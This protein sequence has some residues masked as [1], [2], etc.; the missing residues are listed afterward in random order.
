MRNLKALFM[1]SAAFAAMSVAS[2]SAQ[3]QS[4]AFGA[5]STSV[6][7]VYRQLMDCLYDQAQG[8]AGKPGPMAKA[9]MCTGFNTS[10]FHGM[11]LYA[12]TGS[13]NGKLVLRT[14]DKSQIGIVSH[15]VPYTN[16]SKYPGS[17][18]VLDTTGYDGVQ[19]IGSD[20]VVN[21]TDII[22][23][24]AGGTT[25]PQSKFGNLIQLP[26]VIETIGLGLSE[27][28]GNNVWLNVLTAGL[29]LSRNA[30]CGIVSGHITQ[31]NNPILTALNGGVLGTGNIIFVHR[32]DES[33]ATF[34]LSNA[35]VAQCRYEFGPNNET[36]ATIVSY[37]F[38]W[39]DRSQSCS[40]PLVA[41]GSNQVNWPDQFPTDQCG[42]A[43]SNPGGGH[44]ASARVINQN[45]PPHHTTG[46]GALVDF[47][48]STNGAIGYASGNFSI[49]Q[50]RVSL[51]PFISWR[52]ANLQSQWD[53]ANNTGK[54]QAP[55]WQ[56]AQKA[57]ATLIPQFDAT[58][59]ANPLTWSL[60]G[61]APNPVVAGAYPISG[62]S[63]IEMY[64]C[65]RNH[66]TYDGPRANGIPVDNNA[67]LWLKIWLDF[68]YGT[69]S[70]GILNDTGFAQIP[71]VWQ[72]EIYSLLND[73]V[74]GP[75]GSGCSGKVG[76]Y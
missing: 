54:F 22:N 15:S 5:G 63:W 6:Q 56:G 71:G 17:I 4:Y 67:F 55:T 14:N 25:S 75:Q 31:W 61:V 66:N 12:P 16:L 47:V 18:D 60:Q 42:N 37:S 53:L 69:G 65:Y 45:T 13:G 35:L 40:T 46:S 30:M 51:W 39:T 26:A 19:F 32:W 44:F 20:D 62:F 7:I 8:S 74:N 59:R 58:T 38:P 9:W 21:T 48:Q 3:A 24:N 64:Q 43:V 36:D 1:G 33:G 28:D 72:S 76:A 68:L 70:T 73:P 57:M 50:G 41:R 10:G 2:G 27:K 11:I 34:L 49:D 23:W 29:N 52:T